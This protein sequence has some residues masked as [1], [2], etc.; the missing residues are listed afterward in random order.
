MD[1]SIAARLR[2]I[3]I[4]LAPY[5]EP[6]SHYLPAV[7][8]G[9]LVYFSGQLS[10]ME[11]DGEIVGITG[12][13]GATADVAAGYAAARACAIGVLG[14]AQSFLGDLGRVRQVVRLTGYVNTAPG[15]TEQHK[16]MDGASDVFHAAFGEAGRH[17]RLAIGV[18]GLSFDTAVE[19]DC[20]F[21]VD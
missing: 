10:A 7:R 15:F 3:G 5:R 21:A 17:T 9:G 14:R 19:L 4:D 20:V 8:A 1:D 12:R 11:Y 13:L 16:V 18:A 2:A 6:K